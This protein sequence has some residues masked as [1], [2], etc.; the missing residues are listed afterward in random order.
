MRSSF[1][2]A[3]D[4]PLFVSQDHLANLLRDPTPTRGRRKKTK[5]AGRK[6]KMHRPIEEV[7]EYVCEDDDC[8]CCCY[9]GKIPIFKY[10]QH[11]PV[12]RKIR[13]NVRK[14]LFNCDNHKLLSL[15]LL[16]AVLSDVDDM[17]NGNFKEVDLVNL[18]TGEI[19]E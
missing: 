10:D 9:G 16:K 15:R 18:Y 7:A 17:R 19:V 11:E 8:T 1:R 6:H 13:A 4:R 2:K 3:C 12:V 5:G 14:L